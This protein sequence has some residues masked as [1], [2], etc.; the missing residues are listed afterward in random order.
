V[1]AAGADR[2]EGAGK[3]KGAV[4]GR[5]APARD[6]VVEPQ[7]AIVLSILIAQVWLPPAATL[8]SP[9]ALAGTA[10]SASPTAMAVTALRP[11]RP[12]TAS[13]LDALGCDVS[14]SSGG[15]NAA[16]SPHAPN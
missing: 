9:A 14:R 6:G 13:S 11:V 5:V 8:T 4:I 7:H 16:L 10:M 12:I 15:A 1:V 2:G 3:G